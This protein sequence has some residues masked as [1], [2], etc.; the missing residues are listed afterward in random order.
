LHDLNIIHDELEHGAEILYE[1]KE[2]LV[3]KSIQ[4]LIRPKEQLSIFRPMID[5]A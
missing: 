2:G 3:E 5:D 4:K 1:R